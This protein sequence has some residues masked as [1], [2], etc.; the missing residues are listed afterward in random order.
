[1]GNQERT[2]SLKPR[3][4]GM[5][6][7]RLCGWGLSPSGGLHV[8]HLLK[9]QLGPCAAWAKIIDSWGGGEGRGRE[10]PASQ[11]GRGPFTP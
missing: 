10:E 4:L 5:A 2:T 1:M 8:L 7:L 11:E 3:P 6:S 9:Q